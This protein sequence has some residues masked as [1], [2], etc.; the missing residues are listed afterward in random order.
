[1][2]LYDIYK[3]IIEIIFF[4]FFPFENHRNKI[5]IYIIIHHLIGN[6]KIFLKS[7]SINCSK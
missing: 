6:L 1:M 3:I 2:H 5:N 7:L 4:L